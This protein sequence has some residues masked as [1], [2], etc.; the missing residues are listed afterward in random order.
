MPCQHTLYS[1]CALQHQNRKPILPQDARHVFTSGQQE[2]PNVLIGCPVHRRRYEEVFDC[3]VPSAHVR[4]AMVLFHAGV[5]EADW[6]RRVN[7]IRMY[8]RLSTCCSATCASCGRLCCAASESMNVSGFCGGA[9]AA[10]FCEYI[11]ARVVY[12]PTPARRTLGLDVC[13]NE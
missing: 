10:L 8:S 4:L 5:V 3:G 9:I 1:W 6:T 7:R 13:E 2:S 11:V 12:G